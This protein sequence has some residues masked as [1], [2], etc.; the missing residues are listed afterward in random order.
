MFI[1]LGQKDDGSLREER[2]VECAYTFHSY[3]APLS[4]GS[5]A[6]NILLLW[7]KDR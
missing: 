3:G 5:Q 2:H 4:S 1:A 6:I 7:S